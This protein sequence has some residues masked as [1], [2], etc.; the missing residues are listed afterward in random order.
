MCLFLPVSLPTDRTAVA[1]PEVLPGSGGILA[2]SR[3]QLPFIFAWVT[4]L[5][6]RGWRVRLTLADVR[7]GA[8]GAATP[9]TAELLQRYDALV[10][11]FEQR[12]WKMA[13][14]RLAGSAIL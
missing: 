11:S 2:R 12:M 14:L 3:M 9:K 5:V 8:V 4:P 6:R 7:D 1:S 13:R 10:G